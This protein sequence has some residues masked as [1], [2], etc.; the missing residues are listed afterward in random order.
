MTQCHPP[1]VGGLEQL[2]EQP[3]ARSGAR[4]AAGTERCPLG[5]GG[6]LEWGSCSFQRRGMWAGGGRSCLAD[7]QELP[8]HVCMVS[9]HQAGLQDLWSR[10]QKSSLGWKSKTRGACYPG[11]QSVELDSAAGRSLRPSGPETRPQESWALPRRAGPCWA[12]CRTCRAGP[13]HREG[14][15]VPGVSPRA[16]EGKGSGVVHAE[17][18]K[19][20]AAELKVPV[21]ES[22]QCLLSPKVALGSSCSGTAPPFQTSFR[23]DP[24][25]AVPVL[26][27]GSEDR[28]TRGTVNFPGCRQR[29][30]AVIPPCSPS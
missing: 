22:Q 24:A 5:R 6:R 25:Q 14:G 7:K 23:T 3:C 18:G 1:A 27:L 30:Q 29:C 13:C 15:Q 17:N 8:G 9:S 28:S 2:E 19:C 12:A 16:W 11:L 26:S 20:L 10:G 21:P 4:L